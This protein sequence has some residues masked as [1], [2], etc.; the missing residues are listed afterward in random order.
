MNTPQ[1]TPSAIAL[2][3]GADGILIATMNLPG[4]PM[5][6]VGPTLMAGIAAAADRLAGDPA[7][8]GLVL[9]SAKADFCAGGDL[10]EM[11]TWTRPEQPFEASMAMKRVLR[12]LETCGKPVA[13]ALNGHALGGGLEIALACHP[14]L[15]L[16]DPRLKLGHPEVNPGSPPARGGAH[17]LARRGGPRRGPAAPARAA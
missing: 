16:G 1:D 6:V 11:F 15:A 13:A 2:E 5:N 14:R 3:L 8:L 17:R 4:R 12:R 10:D 7:V 9:A